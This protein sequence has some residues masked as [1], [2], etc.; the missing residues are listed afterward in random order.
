[1]ADS[2]PTART[3]FFHR[4]STNELI[5]LWHGRE[6]ARYASV[7]EFVDAHIEG[8]HALDSSQDDLLEGLYRGPAPD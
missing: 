6:I 5:L 2:T 1:M 3:G 4:K 7:E 8:L